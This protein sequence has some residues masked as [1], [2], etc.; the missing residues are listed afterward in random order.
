MSRV[1]RPLK[2]LYSK[3]NEFAYAM[4][5]RGNDEAFQ[6]GQLIDSGDV[7]TMELT[8]HNVECL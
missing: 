5:R 6:G 3:S 8:P 7:H 1:M 4:E 2:L